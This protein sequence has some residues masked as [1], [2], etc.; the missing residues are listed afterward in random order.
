MG[1]NILTRYIETV[2][3]N[4]PFKSAVC[5]S[6]PFNVDIVTKKLMPLQKTLYDKHLNLN[7]KEIV[8]KNYQILKQHEAEIGYDL[9]GALTSKNVREF[10]KYMT[11]PINGFDNLKDFYH[12]ISSGHYIKDI[13]IPVLF[14]HS[15]DDP[16]CVKECIPIDDI[17]K[18]EN[19]IL[20]LTQKGGHIEW[21]TGSNPKRWA[22][23]PTLEFLTYH[24]EK[25]GDF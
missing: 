15:L 10:D 1:A 22:Y 20:I 12:D 7:S 6:V 9:D 5:M 17:E 13:S 3:K 24:A 8:Q 14:I 4:C 21:F 25:N 2:G 11:A 16:V 23:K 18:N 19:C